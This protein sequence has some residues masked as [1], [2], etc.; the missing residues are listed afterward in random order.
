MFDLDSTTPILLSEAVSFPGG[1]P[2]FGLQGAALVELLLPCS[3]PCA[4]L[5]TRIS[6]VA[7]VGILLKVAS[8]SCLFGGKFFVKHA[9]SVQFMSD[10]CTGGKRASPADENGVSAFTRTKRIKIELKGSL[11]G[12][13]AKAGQATSPQQ[14]QQQPQQQEAPTQ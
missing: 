12:A 4:Q 7:L 11:D 5:P 2:F 3:G 8:L 13:L 9:D 6:R 10:C 14:Q 1:T